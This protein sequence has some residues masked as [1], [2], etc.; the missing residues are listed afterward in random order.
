VWVKTL[1]IIFYPTD[2]THNTSISSPYSVGLK[3]LLYYYSFQATT[4]DFSISLLRRSKSR[5]E[6]VELTAFPNSI[7]MGPKVDDSLFFSA[8]LL[9]RVLIS[10]RSGS[11]HL[12]INK[13][14]CT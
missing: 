14:V 11:V 6:M 10:G 13:W 5:V 8:E 7:L 4:I 2:L 3:E 12:S 1:C 9:S